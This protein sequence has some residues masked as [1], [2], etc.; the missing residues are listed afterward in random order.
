[1]AAGSEERGGE[2]MYGYTAELMGLV[3]TEYKFN[4]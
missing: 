1:M 4:G 3:N 2:V